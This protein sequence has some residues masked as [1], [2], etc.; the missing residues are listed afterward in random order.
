MVRP[1]I[2]VR[3]RFYAYGMHEELDA[4]GEYILHE[5]TGILSA[6]LPAECVGPGGSVVC[7]TRLLPDIKKLHFQACLVV[8][9]AY[10]TSL[11]CRRGTHPRHATVAIS[12]TH[13]LSVRH[14]M[15]LQHGGDD[16]DHRRGPSASFAFSSFRTRNAT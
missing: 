9:H 4:P 11:N 15:P 7:Q 5:D 14:V 6:V 8:G 1:R 10:L 3:P 12:V 2:R 16:S 13:R